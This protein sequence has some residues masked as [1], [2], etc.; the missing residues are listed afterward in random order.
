M[1]R[2]GEYKNNSRRCMT[3]EELRVAGLETERKMVQ[4]LVDGKDNQS[5][6]DVWFSPEKREAARNAFL[7]STYARETALA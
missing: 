3:E 7:R 1:H 2:T 5:V 6:Q 4:F